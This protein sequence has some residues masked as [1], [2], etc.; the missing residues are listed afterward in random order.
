MWFL[1]SWVKQYLERGSLPFEIHICIGLRSEI[2][3]KSWLKLT[4]HWSFFAEHHLDALLGKN[5]QAVA[6]AAV[7]A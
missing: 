1:V 6:D 2:L 4:M 5:A 7:Q 3:Y